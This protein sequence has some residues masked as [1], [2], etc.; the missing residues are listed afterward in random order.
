MFTNNTF[1]IFS[2]LLT[3][4]LYVYAASYVFENLLH[5]YSSIETLNLGASKYRDKN[6][7]FCFEVFLNKFIVLF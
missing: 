4:Q 1:M 2:F 3:T 7:C 5:N 6:F